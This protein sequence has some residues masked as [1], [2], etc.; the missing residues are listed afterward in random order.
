MEPT[1][2]YAELTELLHERG[3]SEVEIGKIIEQARQYEREMQLD[4]IMDSIGAGRLSLKGLIDAAL[5]D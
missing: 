5:K 1:D 3:Y 4:S 2:D